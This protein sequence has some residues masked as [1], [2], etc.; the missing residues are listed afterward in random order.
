[1]TRVCGVN[2]PYVY[3]YTYYIYVYAYMYIWP[4]NKKK[5]ILHFALE[6]CDLVQTNFDRGSLVHFFIHLA[7]SADWGGIATGV[8]L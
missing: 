7:S 8:S 1:M 5:H 2:T 6:G 3:I 4:R